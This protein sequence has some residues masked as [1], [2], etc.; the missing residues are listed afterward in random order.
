MSRICDLLEQLL[1]AL[2]RIAY[3]LEQRAENSVLLD[4]DEIDW[5]IEDSE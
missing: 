1:E 2:N 3:A 5:D 4:F